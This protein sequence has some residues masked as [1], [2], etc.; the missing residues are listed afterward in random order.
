MNKNW[1]TKP[2]KYACDVNNQTLGEDTRSDWKMQY[3]DISAVNSEGSI[4]DLE[5]HTF[6]KAPSRARRRVRSGDTVISTV[7]TY[8]KAIAHF[9]QPPENLVASTGFAV[10][11]PNGEASS[12]FLWRAVQSHGFISKVVA[13][14]QGVGYPAIAP[15][16]LASL[17]ISFPSPADQLRIAAYLDEATGRIDRLV[18]LR[19]R[20]MELLREQRAALI[21]ETVT[22]GLNPSAPLKDSGV[23]WL[24]AIPE[25]WE[26]KRCKVIFREIDNRST[27]GHEELLTVSHLTGITPRTEKDE[28]NMFLAETNEGYKKVEIGD[29][30]I[31][32]MWAWMGALGFSACCGIVSP[33]YNV[34][35]F[36][37]PNEPNYYGFLFRTA[38]FIKEITRYSTGIWESRL[39]LYP[40]AFFEIRAPIPPLEEQQEILAHIQ[41]ETAK[42]D[43]LRRSY[44]RQLTLLAE[45]RAALIHECVTGQKEV[46]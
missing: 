44:E 22:R 32:T 16:R 25:H 37:R 7:R 12:R 28:V 4:S 3:L 45:Y 9:D 23:P 11:S 1:T 18:G 31:N 14:S 15:S 35:R 46:D 34:Y 29:L 27:D 43:A 26:V 36:R 39:R 20:Q 42:L 19:R 41:R 13:N 21:Q 6:A 10:L 40:Q 24:G 2:L 17:S 33:S 38:T 8:L 30:V 5:N